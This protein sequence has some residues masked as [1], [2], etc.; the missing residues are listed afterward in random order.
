MRFFLAE[1][2]GKGFERSVRISALSPEELA[3]PKRKT[4]EE[5][6]VPLKRTKAQTAKA[7]APSSA[8]KNP[9][10]SAEVEAIE[11][12]GVKITQAKSSEGAPQASAKK[13]R[14]KVV[15]ADSNNAEG[16][17]STASDEELS[18]STFFRDLQAALTLTLISVPSNGLHLYLVARH[19]SLFARIQII[20]LF[21][22]LSIICSLRSCP[23]DVPYLL[24]YSLFLLSSVA[25]SC[26]LAFVSYTY[27][28]IFL[29]IITSFRGVRSDGGPAWHSRLDHARRVPDCV[30]LRDG[31]QVAGVGRHVHRGGDRESGPRELPHRRQRVRGLGV[32][33]LPHGGRSVHTA[34][35]VPRWRRR[36][37]H[38]QTGEP[39]QQMPS[40]YAYFHHATPFLVT[41]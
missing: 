30:Q 17:A 25:R 37:S 13:S 16:A 22:F 7:K 35:A 34:G 29:A 2:T 26:C 41:T 39:A 4:A 1:R 8:K 6:E 38:S 5:A 20:C 10:K 12:P 14:R 33:L 27:V 28:Y 32:P 36:Q 15:A 31:P 18:N 23:T 40:L 3:S 9:K 21:L 11:T 24:H 19:E